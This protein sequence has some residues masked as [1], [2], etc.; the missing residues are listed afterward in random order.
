MLPELFLQY[1]TEREAIRMERLEF[2]KAHPNTLFVSKKFPFNERPFCNNARILD[3][4]TQYSLHET[5]VDGYDVNKRLLVILLTRLFMNLSI[6]RSVIEYLPD[7]TRHAVAAYKKALLEGHKRRNVYLS[8]KIPME[9]QLE[10][11]LNL[12]MS[13]RVFK[14]ESLED[15]YNLFVTTRGFGKFIAFQLAQD[16]NY[17]LQH[18]H[19][20][21]VVL[22]SGAIRG[23]EKLRIPK[24]QWIDWVLKAPS[25]LP[26][27]FADG[28]IVYRA[29]HSVA[30]TDEFVYTPADVQNMLCEFDKWTRLTNPGLGHDKKVNRYYTPSPYRMPE[31]LIPANLV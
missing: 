25:E 11:L 3:R 28:R 23:L 24:C 30:V 12:I 15:L 9:E 29:G 7:G 13:G 8:G 18:D 26:T 14:Q 19:R 22:G 21:F 27:Y 20:S 16:A 4:W 6:V 17:V 1:V 2:H 31:I 5:F 10:A